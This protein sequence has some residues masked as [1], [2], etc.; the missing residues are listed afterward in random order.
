MN[1]LLTFPPMKIDNCYCFIEKRAH[2]LLHSTKVNFEND[3]CLIVAGIVHECKPNM[4]FI[5]SAE[6]GPNP[7]D[8]QPIRAS[9]GFGQVVQ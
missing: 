7:I 6:L 5:T 4:Y 2:T 1:E 9:N 3:K 8:G